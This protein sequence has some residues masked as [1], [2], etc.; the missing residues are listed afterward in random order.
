[1]SMKKFLTAGAVDAAMLALSVGAAGAETLLRLPARA[2]P[3]QKPMWIL[4]Y[5]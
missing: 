3:E 4:K 1:M 2:N 5:S